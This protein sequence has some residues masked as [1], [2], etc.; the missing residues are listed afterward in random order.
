[1][2]YVDLAQGADNDT[3]H[4]NWSQPVR[5]DIVISMRMDTPL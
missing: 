2:P 3:I 4:V 5:G 1:M